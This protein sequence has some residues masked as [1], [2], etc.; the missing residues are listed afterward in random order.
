LR[1]GKRQGFPT[2]LAEARDGD[3][4]PKRFAGDLALGSPG[5]PG[6]PVEG[7]LQLR[8]KTYG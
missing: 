5:T 6:D 3:L 2:E 1:F 7:F 8:V 4:A